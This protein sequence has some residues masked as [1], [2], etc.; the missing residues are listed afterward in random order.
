M[1]NPYVIATECAKRCI[2]NN[3]PKELWLAPIPDE[4]KD[5]IWNN[6]E[7]SVMKEKAFEREPNLFNKEFSY[8]TNT[9]M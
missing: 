5:K 4:D 1:L 3:I 7:K 2:I 9:V 8:E 6:A